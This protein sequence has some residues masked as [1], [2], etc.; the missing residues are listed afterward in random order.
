VVGR[1]TY[2]VERG[3]EYVVLG[4]T[5]EN[6]VVSVEVEV[7]PRTVVSAPL[8]LFEVLDAHASSLWVLRLQGDGDLTLWPELFYSDSFHDRLSDDKE[9]ERTSFES[10]RELLTR[11][12][13]AQVL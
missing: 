9:P 2:L 12:A 4:L 13:R 5:I 11:E 10:I 8:S 6:G 7:G 1:T 3:T